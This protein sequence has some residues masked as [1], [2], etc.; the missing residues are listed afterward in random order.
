MNLLCIKN[1]D[2]HKIE[3]R[4]KKLL[5]MEAKNSFTTEENVTSLGT[6][7][8]ATEFSKWGKELEQLA[9][10]GVKQEIAKHKANNRPIFYSRQGVP[11][12]ELADG[13]CFEYRLRP[14]GTEEIIREV[15][16]HSR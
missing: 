11:L 6:E 13:R 5:T 3:V 12:V 9:Q 10:E 15:F 14:D 8:G 16:H 1:S 2:Y 4:N 7:D